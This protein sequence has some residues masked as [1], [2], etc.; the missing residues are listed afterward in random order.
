[1]HLTQ[2]AAQRFQLVLIRR[3][4]ALEQLEHLQHPFHIVERVAEGVD[5]LV[6]LLDCALNARSYRRWWWSR[7]RRGRCPRAWLAWFDFGVLGSFA[8]GC[9]FSL[10]LRPAFGQGFRLSDTRR[11]RLGGVRLGR[12]GPAPPATSTATSTAAPTG[13]AARPMAF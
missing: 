8:G 2:R 7:R 5:D 1:M 9:L 11:R 10:E 3:A 6:Y 4:L 13:P 12:P